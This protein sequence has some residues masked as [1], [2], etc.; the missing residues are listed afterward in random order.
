MKSEAGGEATIISLAGTA[1]L[2]SCDDEELMEVSFETLVTDW[3]PVLS[4]DAKWIDSIPDCGATKTAQL[5]KTK[6]ELLLVVLEAHRKFLPMHQHL[7]AQVSPFKAV[8]VSKGFEIG[9]LTLVPTTYS[10]NVAQAKVP[11]N[12]VNCGPHDILGTEYNVWLASTLQLEDPEKPDKEVFVPPFFLVRVTH[13]SAKS[14]MEVKQKG[15][16][17]S[18]VSLPVMRN[19]KKLVKGDELF[20][21]QEQSTAML[22]PP[23][24]ETVQKKKKKK[25]KKEK[26]I[27]NVAKPRKDVKPK[28]IAM[29][30]AKNKK[31]KKKRTRTR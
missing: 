20:V 13:D 3:Q 22:V 27:P 21:F 5:A 17:A 24:Q 23:A 25:K 12:G 7:Q 10:V 1:S 8:Q 26:T 19:I 2:K 29:R 11:P 31:K 6:A 4:E 18:G 9:G 14:N 28:T 30:N 16:A 15:Y